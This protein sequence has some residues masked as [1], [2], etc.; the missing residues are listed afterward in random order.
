MAGVVYLKFPVYIRVGTN[1][2]MYPGGS[3]GFEQDCA[4]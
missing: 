1:K 2:C 3:L 4:I